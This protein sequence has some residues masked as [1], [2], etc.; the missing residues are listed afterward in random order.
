LKKRGFS[1]LLK[2]FIRGTERVLGP[3]PDGK[4]HAKASA[5]VLPAFK[6]RNRPFVKWWLDESAKGSLISDFPV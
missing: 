4:T 6:G 2:L 1:E 3:K 5:T